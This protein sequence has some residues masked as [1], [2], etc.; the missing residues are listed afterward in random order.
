MGGHP[1]RYP[2][3]FIRELALH[4]IFL[5]CTFIASSIRRDFVLSRP[6]L[7]YLGPILRLV[8]FS[9]QFLSICF[10]ILF[11][12]SRSSHGSAPLPCPLFLQPTRA[13]GL[14]TAAGRACLVGASPACRARVWT[15]PLRPTPPAFRQLPTSPWLLP[16]ALTPF[17]PPRFPR[18]CRDRG[19]VAFGPLSIRP[20]SFSSSCCLR[21]EYAYVQGGLKGKLRFLLSI[22]RSAKNLHNVS[23]VL[24]GFVVFRHRLPSLAH[25]THHPPRFA[26][27]IL[28]FMCLLT[29]QIESHGCLQVQ[30][31]R[32]NDGLHVMWSDGSCT[33]IVDLLK[34]KH[35]KNSCWVGMTAKQS[36]W[37]DFSSGRPTLFK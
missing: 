22:L 16:A 12:R 1:S 11:R 27:R 36:R 15:G 32:T 37:E 31:T 35:L 29:L 6:A 28:C 23:R 8:I 20:R 9:S 24:L 5:P 21:G 30:Q 13:L 33:L 14:R 4:I 7:S 10:L 18:V 25:N 17:L 19:P 3:I 34:L 26:L 2:H